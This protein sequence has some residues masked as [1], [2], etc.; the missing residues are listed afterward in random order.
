[1]SI[2]VTHWRYEICFS[3]PQVQFL[4]AAHLQLLTADGEI[5]DWINVEPFLHGSFL[6]LTNNLRFVS[7]DNKDESGVEAA[8]ALSHFSYVKSGGKEMVVDLQGWLPS[9]G[10]G[11][12]YLTDPVFHTLYRKKFSTCDHQ[13]EGMKAFWKHVHPKCNKICAFLGLQKFRPDIDI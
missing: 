5:F 3:Y 4:T 12:V 13:E 7:S 1:M 8:T 9:Q 10:K 2:F 6:K 11:I